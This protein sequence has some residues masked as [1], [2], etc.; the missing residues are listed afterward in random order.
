MSILPR[1]AILTEDLPVK[2]NVYASG[3]NKVNNRLFKSINNYITII[4]SSTN[5]NMT[6][7]KFVDGLFKNKILIHSINDK[8]PILVKKIINKIVNSNIMF[9]LKLPYMRYKLNKSKANW[10]FCPCGVDPKG[11]KKSVILSKYCNIPLAV[12]LVD[13][14]LSGAILSNNKKN[15]K[16]AEKNVKIF[17]RHCS[18]IFVISK[19]FKKRIELLY[20]VD[21]TVLPLPY[22]LPKVTE[23]KKEIKVKEQIMFVGSISH[24]YIEGLKD[25]AETI[26]TI[27]KNENVDLKFRFTQKN[28]EH[29]KSLVGNYN[30]IVSKPYDE[31]KELYEALSNSLICFAPYSFD[32]K[33]KE[34]V[35]TSFPSKMLDYLSMAKMIL[36]YSPKYSTSIQYFEENN[37]IKSII[38]RDKQYLYNAILSQ[39]KNTEDYS[40]TYRNA[41]KSVHS[42][43]VIKTIIINELVK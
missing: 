32:L 14:F 5:S 41:V 3:M 28:E 9:I 27:N 36:V 15:V 30:C 16:I 43:E 19:G 34:M 22:E 29:V 20:G 1:I 4:F 38:V 35:S 37:L 8:I 7:I 26:E 42:F 18:K 33:F 12:Y 10:L 25:M 2:E 31:S 39:I 21:S 40:D 23:I 6:N 24:F 13:D 17:L 11:L